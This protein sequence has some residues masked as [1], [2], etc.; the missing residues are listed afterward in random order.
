M[1][2]SNCKSKSSFCN[3]P[4]IV[5]CSANLVGQS[6]IWQGVVRRSDFDLARYRQKVQ[7]SISELPEKLVTFIVYIVQQPKQF[8]YWSEYK[9]KVKHSS[10]S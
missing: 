8:I 7:V 6:F 10:Q 3:L 1:G 4:L 9:Q 2:K 5:I